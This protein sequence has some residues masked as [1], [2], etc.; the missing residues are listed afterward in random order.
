MGRRA[1]AITAAAVVVA[2]VLAGGAVA[3]GQIREHRLTV[4]MPAAS[5]LVA[6]TA[7]Q[8]NGHDAGTI[9]TI[10]TRDGQAMIEVGLNPDQTGL[11]D[12]TSARIRWN[13]VLGERI[14]EL[15][16][17][18]TGG[19][20][21]P[22]G[23]LIRGGVAPVEFDDL[24]ATLDEP[25]RQRLVSL[26]GRL[27]D[28]LAGSE[29]DVNRTLQTAGPAVEALGR[30]LQGVG[31]DG[32]A[33][34]TLITH[35]E[36]LTSRVADR[37]E[38][39][40]ATVE[41]LTRS[42]GELAGRREQLRDAL[43]ELPSTLAAVRSTM[44]RVPAAVDAT[45][46]LLR[47][48]EPATGRLPEVSRKLAPLLA[49]LRPATAEL[50]PTLQAATVL[51]GRT[52]ALLDSAHVAL[53]QAKTTLEQSSDAVAFLRPYTPEIVG[54]LANWGSFAGNYDSNGH[55][56][57]V[58]SPQSATT[59]TANPGVLPPGMTVRRTPAPGELEDQPW[60]D[61]TGSGIR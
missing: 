5:N 27:D 38:S 11:P 2:L 51:L 17:G 49:D 7:V 6:G 35:L 44:D 10:T 45:A 18:P 40:S 25:T 21:L 56:T 4:V 28:T 36:D 58:L 48:L 14:L 12:G 55:Y 59:V 16:P 32:P 15:V 50:R 24:L 42:T 54:F 3:L 53:P 8:V 60:T 43:R 37:R 61:A 41:Q 1:V 31:S 39:V 19:P 33:I 26:V 30:V 34:R 29:G 47:D 46:P 20:A 52:P 23:A 22:D 57:R 13:A 9:R